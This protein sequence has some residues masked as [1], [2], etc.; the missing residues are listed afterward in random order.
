ML[1]HLS[2]LCLHACDQGIDILRHLLNCFDIVTVF[3]INLSLEFPDKF[4]LVRY[5]LGTSSFLRLNVLLIFKSQ[6]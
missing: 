2:K 6:R 5:N 4:G 1:T 3:L